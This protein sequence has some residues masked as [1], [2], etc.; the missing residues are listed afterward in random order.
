MAFSLVPSAGGAVLPNQPV[1]AYQLNLRGLTYAQLSAQT[2]VTGTYPI[3]IVTD[4][5]ATSGTVSAGGSTHVNVV[6]WT[7]SV[8]TVLKAVS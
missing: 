5:S 2:P 8:W 6:I 4:A 3:A 7:G 1:L